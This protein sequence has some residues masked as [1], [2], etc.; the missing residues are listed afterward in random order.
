MMQKAGPWRTRPFSQH[1]ESLTSSMMRF[2]R[3]QVSKLL[4]GHQSLCCRLL[5]SDRR[6]PVC[7]VPSPMGWGQGKSGLSPMLRVSEARGNL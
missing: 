3:G 7:R 5:A 2:R 1:P 6:K 4:H